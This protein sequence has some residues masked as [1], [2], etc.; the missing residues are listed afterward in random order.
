MTH[1]FQEI[2][3]MYGPHFLILY[4]IVIALT[5]GISRLI[6]CSRDQT[7]ELPLPPFPDN[8]DP[9][10]ISY[11][12]GGENEV[13]RVFIFNLIQRGYLAEAD[14]KLVQALE[15]PDPDHLSSL[16]R[17]IFDY[18]S[19]ERSANEVFESSGL[20]ERVKRECLIYENRFQQ[21]SLLCPPQRINAAWQVGLMGGAIVAGL[22][23][24]KL[25]ASLSTGHS[26]VLFLIAMGII[27]LVIQVKISLPDR[28]SRLG[29]SYLEKLTQR[30]KGLKKSVV[31]GDD[32]VSQPDNGLSLL[33][34]GLYGLSVL[35]DTQYMG[36][37]QMF[38]N[39]AASGGCGGG[40][41][42]GCDG[43]CGGCGGCG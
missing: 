17:V 18:F 37:N 33:F 19:S 42:G 23:G 5:L 38:T 35:N 25:Y 32:D 6:L 43:G 41:G 36:L 3:K 9:Y 21:E 16:E 20:P 27:A 22:G 28:L 1:I 30:Y 39:K 10:E 7:G 40:C 15:Q 8:P 4:G 29:H 2:A 34:V 12:R 11:L 31:I 14:G 26:N 13:T 24:Y